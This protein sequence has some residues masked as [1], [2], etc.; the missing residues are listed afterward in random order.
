[1]SI[2]K[3]FRFNGNTYKRYYIKSPN[4]KVDLEINDFVNNKTYYYKLVRKSQME[5]QIR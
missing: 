2:K 5:V 3:S 1:M 4:N